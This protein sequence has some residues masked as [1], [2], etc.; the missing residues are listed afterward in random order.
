MRRALVLLVALLVGAALLM[1][2]SA[3][4]AKKG[5]GDVYKPPYKKGNQGGDEWNYVNAD[6]QTGE[7]EILRF[8]PGFSPIVGCEPEPAAGWATLKQSHR[9]QGSADKVT[10]RFDAMLEPYAWLTAVVWDANKDSLGLAK[11]QGPHQ[12]TGAMKINLFRRPQ[13][14]SEIT[15]EFGAQLGDSCPQVGGAMVTFP[16]IEVD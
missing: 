14:G 2:S 16:S 15:V 13:P 10:V 9:V 6:P 3:V 5:K 4:A 12:G 8:F 11:F 7:V 1:P